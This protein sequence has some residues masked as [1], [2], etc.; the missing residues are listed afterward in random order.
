MSFSVLCASD[1]RYLLSV[2]RD[3]HVSLFEFR[4]ASDPSASVGAG[5]FVGSTKLKAHARIIWSCSWAPVRGAHYF[6][7]GSRDKSVKCFRVDA[8]GSAVEDA[9]LPVFGAAVTAVAF[10]PMAPQRGDKMFPEAAEL[11]AA[12]PR[13]TLAVGL[14]DG[15]IELWQSTT[16]LGSER[17]QWTRLHSFHSK[18]VDAAPDARPHTDGTRAERS[19]SGHTHSTVL[20]SLPLLCFCVRL[21]L[22]APSV[23]V[24]AVASSGSAGDGAAHRTRLQSAQRPPPISTWPFAGR[25]SRCASLPCPRL[26]SDSLLRWARLVRRFRS[27]P[28][29]D[30]LSQ[31]SHC[32]NLVSDPCECCVA[33]VCCRSVLL[34]VLLRRLLVLVLLRAS[35]GR[36]R[37]LLPSRPLAQPQP[38]AQ[39]PTSLVLSRPVATSRTHK[40][41]ARHTQRMRQ[42][43]RRT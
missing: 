19:L 40:H 11:A 43:W 16:P 17:L 32:I 9:C 29:L 20:T 3:R 22:V 30:C 14:E 5:A 27:S 36:G 37:R 38:L 2:S 35:R 34:L 1:N 41:S 24:W 21:R 12:A 8:Q 25:I 28:P 10:A 33:C 6:A 13:L 15:T 18:S 31:I 39:R 26:S 23:C 42:R 7:T 4:A